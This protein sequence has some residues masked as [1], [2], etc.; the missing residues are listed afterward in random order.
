MTTEYTRSVDSGGTADSNTTT[1]EGGQ[2]QGALVLGGGNLG[3]LDVYDNLNGSVR[4][5]WDPA[6]QL[7]PASWNVY[8]NGVLNQ[9]VA[10]LGPQFGG[11]ATITGLTQVS[12][13][14]GAIAPTPNNSSRPQNMPPNGVVTPASTY[15]IFVRAVVSGV[16]VAESQTVNVT[17]GPVSIMLTTPMRRPWPFPDMN[18]GG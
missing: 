8:L 3:P 10:G 1:A 16:E 14:Q 9:N 2:I 6:P 15:A 18:P 11:T 7:N 12:Y 17:P 5:A 13:S 4:I